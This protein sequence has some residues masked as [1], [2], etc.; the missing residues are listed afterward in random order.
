M[1]NPLIKSHIR[2]EAGEATETLSEA[3][4]QGDYAACRNSG[5][6]FSIDY[7]LDL[8]KL[9]EALGLIEDKEGAE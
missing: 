4:L 9:R 6:I 1:S 5:L 7:L 3:L 2:V 8:G